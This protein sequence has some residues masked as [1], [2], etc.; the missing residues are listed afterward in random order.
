[1]LP[2]LVLEKC[3]PCE[4]ESIK[5]DLC[6][7]FGNQLASLVRLLPNAALLRMSTQSSS[8]P[9]QLDGLDGKLRI[10]YTLQLFARIISSRSRPIVLHLDDIQ[11]ADQYSL[12]LLQHILGDIK[13]YSSILFVGSF[14]NNE[15]GDE[16]P[17]K[18]RVGNSLSSLLLLNRQHS[19]WI[20]EKAGEEWDF[21]K[22]YSL[23]GDQTG[24]FE[25]A[26]FK[27][28]STSAPILQRSVARGIP[29][30]RRQSVSPKKR[31]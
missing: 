2:P 28:T 3:N 21:D 19:E 1:M 16:H 25:C 9:S 10:D 30:N 12:D 29:K 24:K 15:L 27:F 17:G 20:H 7:I 8:A 6:S 5:R 18:I 11:H 14:R 4:I 23:G 13:G 26:G 31:M 22:Q